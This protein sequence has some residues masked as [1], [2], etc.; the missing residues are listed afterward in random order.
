MDGFDSSYFGCGSNYRSIFIMIKKILFI[1][2]KNL[3]K[4]ALSFMWDY[5][6]KNDD[7]RISKEEL[8]EFIAYLKELK[9]RV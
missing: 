1:I 9:K 6:D 3:I 8:N 7:G 5:L 2:A 4:W